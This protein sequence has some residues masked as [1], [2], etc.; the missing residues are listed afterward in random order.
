MITYVYETLP[1]PGKPAR[2]Y[3]I[4]QSIKDAPLKKHPKTGEPIRRCVVLGS[5]PFV[6]AATI[7]RPEP[8]PKKRPRREPDHHDHHDH[9]H[10]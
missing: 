3:E 2:R 8:R 6:R 7:E 10:H 1:R 4:Q 9:H 5:D